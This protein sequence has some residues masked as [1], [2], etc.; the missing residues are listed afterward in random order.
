MANPSI[1]LIKQ[2]LLKGIA[3]SPAELA[4]IV[5]RLVD[6]EDSALTSSQVWLNGDT[7]SIST[8]TTVAVTDAISL[9]FTGG[10]TFSVGG[11]GGAERF[12]RMDVIADDISLA[13]VNSA[14]L[15]NGDTVGISV[16][17]TT[18]VTSIVGNSLGSAI[19]T[20]RTEATNSDPTVAI[21]QQTVATTNATITTLHTVA[22]PTNTAVLIR[23]FVVARRTGGSAG[24]AD[25]SAAYQVTG[26]YKNVA[27]T[28]TAIGT[29][30]ITVIGESQVGW[31]V[32]LPVSTSNILIRVTGALNNN[33][34][35]HLA[36]LKVMSVST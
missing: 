9:E 25:D 11:S 16:T 29:P 12:T 30:T 3:P 10:N 28:A 34:T 17:A 14:H 36:E 35:W 32:T 2:N 19:L 4:Y 13:A 33:I 22:I 6:V 26:L 31:D 5:E 27:G 7:T 1:E 23:G 20:Y 15:G 18:G 21:Y 8:N 24:A